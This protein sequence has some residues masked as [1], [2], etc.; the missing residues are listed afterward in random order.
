MAP[1][2]IPQLFA[3][4]YRDEVKR[5]MA[6]MVPNSPIHSSPFPGHYSSFAISPQLWR[7]L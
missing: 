6:F 2:R 4:E 5:A 3:V 1:K 7:Q